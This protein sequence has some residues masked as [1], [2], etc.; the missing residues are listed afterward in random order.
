MREEMQKVFDEAILKAEYRKRK[1]GNTA[2]P[3]N[4]F[5]AGWLHKRLY[6]E[7]AEYEESGNSQ[8]L[9]DVINIACFLR[10]LHVKK[11][12]DELPE[13]LEVN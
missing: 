6:D 2:T 11:T 9:L 3:W 1:P 7:L 4:D 8:E 13:D 5:S 12:V 10:I